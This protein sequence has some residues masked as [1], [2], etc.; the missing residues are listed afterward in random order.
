MATTRDDE[1]VGLT[2]GNEDGEQ[3][4]EEIVGRQKAMTM[5]D[6]RRISKSHYHIRVCVSSCSMCLFYYVCCYFHGH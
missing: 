3:N 4:S 6:L 5:A 1:S 2:S